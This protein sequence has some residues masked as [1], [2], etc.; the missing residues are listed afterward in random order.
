MENWSGFGHSFCNFFNKTFVGFGEIHYICTRNITNKTN[1][2]YE[3]I[4]YPRR[5]KSPR[6]AGMVV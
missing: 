2:C 3:S 1:L 5:R 4:T 6:A